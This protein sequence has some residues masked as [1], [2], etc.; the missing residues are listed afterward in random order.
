MW[1]TIRLFVPLGWY[2]VFPNKSPEVPSDLT[3]L[4]PTTLLV[5]PSGFKKAGGALPKDL[6]GAAE[7]PGR[8]PSC[9]ALKRGDR[10]MAPVYRGLIAVAAEFTGGG[11][12]PGR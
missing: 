8:R 2:A 12:Q 10:S 7:E 9:E 5:V 11:W 1:P 3:S 6:L 4:L